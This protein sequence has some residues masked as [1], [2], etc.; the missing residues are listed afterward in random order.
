MNENI[1]QNV[2]T[3]ENVIALDVLFTDMWKGAKRFKWLIIVLVLLCAVLLMAY[4]SYTYEPLYKAEATFTIG[5]ENASSYED[6]VYGYDYSTSTASQLQDTFPYLLES[7]I[8][9]QIL[10]EDLGVDEIN[11]TITASVVTETNLFTLSVTSSSAE[12]AYAILDSVMNNY[13]RI[14]RYVIGDTKLNILMEPV[15]PTEI[16]NP[17]SIPITLIKGAAVGFVL[18]IVV[19]AAYALTRRTIRK[20]EDIRK[21]LNQEC[22]C[23]VPWVSLKKRKNKS[24]QLLLTN[25]NVEMHYE[26]SIRSLRSRVLK[27]MED[28]AKNILMMTSTVQGEGTTTLAINLA[29]SLSTLGKKVILLDANIQSPQIAQMLGLP[30]KAKG[31]GEV[32][33]GQCNVVDALVKWADMD[34]YVLSGYAETAN[35]SKTIEGR[36][37]Q[38]LLKELRPAADYIIIDTPPCSV[39]A[40][41]NGVARYADYAVYVVAQ[42]DARTDQIMDGIQNLAYS[43]TQMIGCIFNNA[44][45]G[46]DGYS[47]GNY[48]YG[49]GYGKY[50]YKKYGDYRKSGY[51]QKRRT[52][53]NTAERKQSR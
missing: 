45:V 39:M 25:S 49:Y 18:G 26:E 1:D 34:L 53:A 7:E 11:G 40:D 16:S 41:A 37:M 24:Q 47:Y 46:I 4:T 2:E 15:V 31:L 5:M 6:D 10:L 28:P 20:N 50:G 52:Q 44:K 21:V 23:T 38:T 17:L 14:A 12:D 42:D 19:V 13:P 22:L 35:P 8:M 43:H 3:E 36:A 9:Q 33:S 32:L 48:G 29:I 27:R 51:A 30:R